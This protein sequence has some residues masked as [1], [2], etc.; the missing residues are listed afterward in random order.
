MDV[1][2]TYMWLRE[3]G[4]PYYVGKGKNRRAFTKHLNGKRQLYPP[5]DSARILVQEFP[6]EKS[7]FEAER[8]LIA[9]YGRIDKGTG[10]LRNFTDGGEGPSGFVFTEI[11]RQKLRDNH[12][13]ENSAETRRKISKANLGRKPPPMSEEQK[14]KQ[15]IFLKGNQYARG[16]RYTLSPEQRQAISERMKG[17][18]NANGHVPSNETRLKISNANSG[19][20]R[21]FEQCR[22]NSEA[23]LG[24]K[25]W[26][27]KKHTEETKRKISESL[28]RLAA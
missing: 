27:G 6:E 10:C 23:K 15:R 8:F 21:S 22:R 19:K 17:N 3:D 7:A 5:L 13:G 1:F 26:L 20:K 28:R 12:R 4:T 24:N 11:H 18:K 9:Y 16:N 14:Q 25:F 2:Y